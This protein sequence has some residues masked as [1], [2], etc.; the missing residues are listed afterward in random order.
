MWGK[1]FSD[2]GRLFAILMVG[3]VL[4]GCNPVAIYFGVHR[5]QPMVATAFAL[6]G[7]TVGLPAFYVLTKNFGVAGAATAAALSYSTIA[8]AMVTWYWHETGTR[9]S[10]LLIPGREDLE[11]L[12][13]E[14]G[15]TLR[16]LLR[17]QGT[18]GENDGEK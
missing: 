2:A 13:E 15:R 9:P 6:A 8:A 17:R 1:G 14:L 11:T 16:I 3:Y 18:K 5:G 4:M 10:R 7:P 12:L